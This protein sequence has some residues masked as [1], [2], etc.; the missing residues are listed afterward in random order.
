LRIEV[1][2]LGASLVEAGLSTARK[3][4][5]AG[6]RGNLDVDWRR[7]LRSARSLIDAE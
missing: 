5:L 1:D 4:S 7:R 3:N 2:A 6:L